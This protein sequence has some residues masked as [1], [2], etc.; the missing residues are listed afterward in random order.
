[1]VVWVKS[2]YHILEL[3]QDIMDILEEAEEARHGMAQEIED[4]EMVGQ[5]YMVE[6]VM[7]DLMAYQNIQQK[8]ECQILVEVVVVEKETGQQVVV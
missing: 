7:E 3:M 5:D 1:M 4:M 2:L 8:M 6:E